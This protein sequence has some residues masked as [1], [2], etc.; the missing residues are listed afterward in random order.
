MERDI[1]RIVLGM[2]LGDRDILE[3]I[4][5]VVIPEFVERVRFPQ[6]LGGTKKKGGRTL[7]SSGV[8]AGQREDAR[9]R[10]VGGLHDGVHHHVLL[11]VAGHD[12]QDEPAT[13]Q[14]A[15]DDHLRVQRREEGLDRFQGE[16][17][18]RQRRGAGPSGV[19][20]D[21]GAFPFPFLSLYPTLPSHYDVHP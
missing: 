7:N 11:R 8:W 16:A 10:G 18:L 2:A 15:V 21:E 17:H 3:K 14:A 9:V 20:R 12:A 6:I 1:D 19:H 5:K 4:C 13:S